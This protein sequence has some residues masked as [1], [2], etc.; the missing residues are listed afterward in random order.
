MYRQKQDLSQ[1]GDEINRKLYPQDVPGTAVGANRDAHI[2]YFGEI[3][4]AYLIED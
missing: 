4:S 1:L 2:T 3:V